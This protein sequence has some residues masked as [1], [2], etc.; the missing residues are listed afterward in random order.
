ML[1]TRTEELL[2]FVLPCGARSSVSIDRVLGVSLGLQRDGA[3][4]LVASLV[5]ELA[6]GSPRNIISGSLEVLTAM[7]QRIIEVMVEIPAAPQ[8]IRA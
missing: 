5:I 1:M 8:A 7:Q 4:G 3:R 6:G 2:E